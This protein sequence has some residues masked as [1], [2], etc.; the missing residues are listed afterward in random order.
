M[1]GAAHHIF[2][3]AGDILFS[4]AIGAMCLLLL[5]WARWWAVALIVL[6]AGIA[7][8]AVPMLQWAGAIAFGLTMVVLASCY[9]ISLP[10]FGRPTVP[11]HS[12]FFWVAGLSTA[13]VAALAGMSPEGGIPAEARWPMIIVTI[14]LLLL[15]TLSW[16]FKDPV[17]KRPR[18]LGPTMYLVPM[19]IMLSFGLLQ[20]FGP[21]RPKATEAQIAAAMV[22]AKAIRAAEEAGKPAAKP[23]VDAKGKPIQ[24]SPT[25]QAALRE[26]S[27]RLNRAEHEA[28]VATERKL[29]TGPSYMDL[30][31]M[32]AA[33]FV[34]HAPGE[35]GFST[36]IV[37][38]FLLG[39][40]FVRTGIMEHTR[41]HLPL[42]RKMAMIGIPLGV[43]MGIAASF[44]STGQ[45]PGLDRDPYQAAM[46]IMMI[47][48]LPAC[49]GYVGMLVL[50]VHSNGPFSR[51][52]VLAPLGRMAL[53]N[54]LT[55]SLVSS[56]FFFGYAGGHFGMHRATQVGF[57]FA[58]IA[59]QVVFCHWWLS[60]FRYGPMEWLWR[61]FT[62]W[63]LPA[64]R[65]EDTPVAISAAA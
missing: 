47:G 57:V 59:L 3:W 33:K 4:Y 65:R 22:E 42:F 9:H 8:A 41:E 62:Y 48:N 50:M 31:R 16:R 18:R 1:F 36:L 49:L 29:L 44:I 25:E 51:I 46:A 63:Q 14:F 15:G 24:K 40:W 38:M 28:E 37:G 21:E 35:F 61:A 34:E 17:D 13:T 64:M 5:M 56:L 12:V 43:G 53:T 52:R 23:P 7:A 20:V 60:K 6:A 26:A 2:L 54:Y 11:G 19:C 58:V 10:N 27:R 55:Q 39:Y 32:R 30:V 45:T